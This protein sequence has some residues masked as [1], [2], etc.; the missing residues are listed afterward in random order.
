MSTRRCLVI[1]GL[2]ILATAIYSAVIATRLPDIVPTHWNAAGHVDK[3]GSKWTTVLLMPCM[4]IGMTALMFL[5]P[6]ISPK[7][8]E[9]VPFLNTFNY[10]IVLVLC[11][12]AVLHVVIA[13]ATLHEGFPMTRVMPAVIYLFFAL[14][15]NVLG[16]V[17]RNFWVGIRTPWTLADERVWDRTHRLAA[18]LW[19][20]GGIVGFLLSLFGLPFTIV[21]GLLMVMALYPVVQSYLIY[22]KLDRGGQIAGP[23][24]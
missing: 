19:T 3:Y 4:M 12:F 1:C 6:K 17:K 10:I 9:I 22:Q 11:M 16:K 15:G 23:G 8:F 21:F 24:V 20:V 7:K 18:R 5:L 14:L 2:I 13:Q